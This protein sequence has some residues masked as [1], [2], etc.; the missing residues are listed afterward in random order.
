MLASARLVSRVSDSTSERK[1]QTSNTISS[2]KKNRRR[3]S[4][5]RYEEDL[6]VQL[7]QLAPTSNRREDVEIFISSFTFVDM[8]KEKESQTLR[9]FKKTNYPKKEKGYFDPIF[10]IAQNGLL[11]RFEVALNYYLK[12]LQ[13]CQLD[14]R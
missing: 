5:R 14:I 12:S 9:R 10:L 2:T 1:Q 13:V 3:E 7:T 8:V 11:F 6:R 4:K